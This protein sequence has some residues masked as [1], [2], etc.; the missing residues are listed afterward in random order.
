MANS[1]KKLLRSKK[2]K[3]VGGV[4][5]GV[6]NYFDVDPVLVRIAFLV[7]TFVN[8]IGFVI[9]ILMWLLIPSSSTS[10]GADPKE[11]AKE[12]RNTAQ[13]IINKLEST[14]TSAPKRSMGIGLVVIGT[15]FLLNNFGVIYWNHIVKF[16]PLIIVLLGISILFKRD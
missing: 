9:Y 1:T 7:L 16:W 8:G 15:F 12:I 11:S 14:N 2:D 3:V 13:T 6:A 10:K 5:S 4:A